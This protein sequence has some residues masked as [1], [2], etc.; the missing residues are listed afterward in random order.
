MVVLVRTGRLDE[1]V[2]W[3][4]RLL[5]EDWISRV[6]MRKAMIETVRSVAAVRAGNSETALSSIREVFATVPPPAWGVVAGLPLSVAVR[7]CTELGDVHAARAYLAVPVPSAMLDTP[8]AVPYLQ[9]LGRYHA[10]MDHPE[11]AAM[12]SRSCQ[13]LM[14]SWDVDAAVVAAALAEF[15]SPRSTSSAIDESAG[16]EAEDGVRLT[17]AERRVAALAAAGNTNREI[18]ERLFIT[19]STVEQ[20]L[21]KVYRKLNVR[22]R[23]ALRRY[24]H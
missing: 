7:A 18:A 3:C 4:D 8:F 22:S 23:S 5:K 15:D 10:A 19:V 20:H 9:A 14:K 13:E 16:P 1:A 6:P 24:C 2:A 12:Y 11:S 21:T 17:E